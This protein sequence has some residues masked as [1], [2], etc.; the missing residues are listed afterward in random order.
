MTFGIPIRE[1]HVWIIS[2][3]YKS[4]AN[5]T[6]SS[7]LCYCQSNMFCCICLL[8]PIYHSNVD[9][10]LQHCFSP[11]IVVKIIRLCT[12]INNLLNDNIKKYNQCKSKWKNVGTSV[13]ITSSLK[14]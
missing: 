9:V 12:S 2:A 5:K 14:Y 6:G 11:F 1:S 4:S 8:K 10:V 3:H 7:L 13:E